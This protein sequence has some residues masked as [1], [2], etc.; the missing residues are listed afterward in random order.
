[1]DCIPGLETAEDVNDLVGV[2]VDVRKDDEDG[3]GGR[4]VITVLVPFCIVVVSF[5]PAV[6]VAKELL[7]HKSLKGKPSRR[8]CRDLRYRIEENRV[9]T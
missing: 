5:E 7:L 2:G 4:V 6:V 1:M 8:N 9:F 3:N